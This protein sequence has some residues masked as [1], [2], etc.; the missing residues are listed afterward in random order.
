MP[1]VLLPQPGV[2]PTGLG[3]EVVDDFRDILYRGMSYCPI[4]VGRSFRSLV[5][6]DSSAVNIAHVPQGAS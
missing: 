4:I 6:V 1:Q 5:R 3:P 2:L